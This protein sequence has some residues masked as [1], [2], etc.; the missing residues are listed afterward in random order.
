MR[1]DVRYALRTLA[2][3]PA[4]TAVAVLTL[5]VGIGATTAIYSVVDAALLRPLPFRDADRLMTAYLRMPVQDG[6]RV[7]DMVWSY[8]K[9][10][11]FAEA[12][13]AFD[14]VALH[15]PEAF[16]VSGTDGA[17][18]ISGELVDASYLPTLGVSAARGRVFAA[19]EDRP[20][21]ALVAVIGD[22]L[23]RRRFGAAPGA[24]GSRME[25][26][27]KPFTI[28]GVLPPGFSG[29]RGG[30]ELWLLIPSIRGA[31]TLGG[32]TVHQFELLARRRA[33]V[34]AGQA[35]RAVAD[36]G[37]AVD[38]TYPDDDGGSWGAAAYTLD[39][40]RVEPALRRSVVVLAGA[41]GLVL[42]IACANVANL[43]L[44]RGAA[45]RREVA[46]RLAIGA[47]AAR[48][49]R[50]LLT[51]SAVLALLGAA[52]GLAVALAAVRVMGAVVP[53]LAASFAA[54]GPG[55]GETA[56][57]T[58][59]ALSALRLDGSAVLFAVGVTLAT[60]LL[61]G[62]APALAAAGV[63]LAASIRQGAAGAPPSGPAF[64]GLRRL[65]GRGLLVSAE[66][67]LAIVLLVAAGL[68]IRSL[69]RLLEAQV[70]YDPE[71]LLTA[72]V[73]LSAARYS[74]DS[75]GALWE[76]LVERAAAL[77]G[78]T[79]AGVGTCTPV[80]DNC[81]GTSIRLL[82][83][84]GSFHVGYFVVSPD[85]FR[86]L[87]IPLLRGRA[88]TARDRPG[89]P[90]VMIVNQAAARTIWAGD[91]PLRVPVAGDGETIAVV[92][93]VGDVRYEDIESPA[94]P[95]IYVPYP[96]S[97]RARGTLVLRT[98]AAD[99]AALAGALRRELR[100]L[101]PGHAV[102]DLKTMRERLHDATARSRFSTTLL[103]AFA[104]VALLLAAVGIYGVMSLAVAQRTR[105]IGIRMALGAARGRVLSMVLA[106][107]MA[108]AGAGVAAGFA[109]A[110]LATR[111][112]GAILY[113]VTPLDPL[114]YAASGV[115]LAL[116][117][118]AAALVPA[119]RA[120]RVN[121]LEAL[122]VEG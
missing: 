27:G 92:G 113:G 111:A 83:R 19:E 70:G 36:A 24:V 97:P 108:L 101:D 69:T 17:E 106:Q 54:F 117:A 44:A 120:T 25:V 4:F 12:Q 72:R 77:P 22:G 45:R 90:P 73:T 6:P 31:G 82:G 3:R 121:P 86:A 79:G 42:L 47:S 21:G 91:D 16:T 38:R 110:V 52:A 55:A 94:R 51:E 57:L 87:R 74:N 62:L 85:Y 71:R 88:F 18:R 53:G 48:I 112:L 100:A 116:A 5:A 63:P 60:G 96:Q 104:A 65:T 64:A 39:E 35:K 20:G 61:F 7:V 75:A 13:S 9:F 59:V 34:T 78:V 2:K 43:L 76:A 67:A 46:V 81:E 8:P 118:A 26:N 115:L 49:A 98:A 99:P 10:R 28:V 23:W 1:Q 84:P 80:G 33:G 41:V 95:A 93:V 32:P 103:G 105:E 114:T 11:A 29:M 30:A 66:V 107:A 40:V 68:T 109:G 56:G 15:R 122:R 14:A 50:Q 119:V 37:R 102:Y 89:A 58:N